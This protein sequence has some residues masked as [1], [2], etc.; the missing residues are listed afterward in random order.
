MGKDNLV[1][2]RTQGFR[3]EGFECG[4]DFMRNT[5]YQLGTFSAFT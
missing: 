5:H 1:A 2:F 4:E 3:F